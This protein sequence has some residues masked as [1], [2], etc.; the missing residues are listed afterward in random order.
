MRR[1]PCYVSDRERSRRSASH[2]ASTAAAAR[3]AVFCAAFFSRSAAAHAARRF[4][5][6]VRIITY[7]FHLHFRSPDVQ[8]TCV[9][10]AVSA[11]LR[12]GNNRFTDA[13]Y[14][15]DRV[16]FQP[17]SIH[18]V[19]LP[20]PPVRLWTSGKR[21]SARRF[22]RA[23]LRP[24]RPAGSEAAHGHAVRRVNTR[25]AL[26]SHAYGSEIIVSQITALR[27]SPRAFAPFRFPHRQYGCGR[28]ARDF[29]RS[30]FFA[31]RRGPCGP[32]LRKQRTNMPFAA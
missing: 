9:F 8:R 14:A 23:A 13:L 4:G 16:T 20:T 26:S 10:S 30:V 2:A 15:K 17:T 27:F 3:H 31:Q 22:S 28:P 18:A 11:C 12:S 29:L 19:S 6:G 7:S 24:M 21:F 32:Q 25:P 1:E 5:S